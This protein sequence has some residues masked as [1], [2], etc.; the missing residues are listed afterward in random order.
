MIEIATSLEDK[1]WEALQSVNDPEI[2]VLSIVDL[3]VIQTVTVDEA[4]N[5][6][7]VTVLPT[8]SGC[9]AL[10]VIESDIKAALLEKGFVNPKV[11]FDFHTPYTTD[12]IT[13]KGRQDLRKWGITPPGQ[14]MVVDDLDVLERIPCPRCGSED[15]EL[16]SPF[17]PA[18][19]RA[20][21]YCNHCNEAFQSFKPIS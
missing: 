10:D 21:H 7:S 15:T 11:S 1:A 20:L 9:P 17:G 13:E 18:L 6:I 19:C 16:R 14:H 12:R 4:Q 2:P 5:S 8:F 3:G